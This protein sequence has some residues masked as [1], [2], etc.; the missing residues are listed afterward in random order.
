MA[1]AKKMSPVRC[2]GIAG[3]ARCECGCDEG[4]PPEVVGREQYG[5]RGDRMP[6]GEPRARLGAALVQLA[7][8]VLV[9]AAGAAHR[10]DT[11][12]PLLSVPK[13]GGIRSQNLVDEP[14]ACF[15]TGHFPGSKS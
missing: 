2:S 6:A 3:V 9:F 14:T 13:P 15:R 1:S 8:A 10:L 7:V 4:A 11:R 12:H 5:E